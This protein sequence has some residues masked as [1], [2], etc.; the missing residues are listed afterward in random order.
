[1]QHATPINNSSQAYGTCNADNSSH[2]YTTCN[3]DDI[4]HNYTSCNTDHIPH[5]YATVGTNRNDLPFIRTPLQA[6]DIVGVAYSNSDQRFSAN[7]VNLRLVIFSTDGNVATAGRHGDAVQTH[8]VRVQNILDRG[9][10]VA[11][12]KEDP[13]I[14]SSCNQFQ[15]VVRPLRQ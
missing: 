12:P 4:P 3:T 6:T 13:S 11:I 8:S 14:T 5:T 2:K 15:L 7:F 10:L 1:M 9:R